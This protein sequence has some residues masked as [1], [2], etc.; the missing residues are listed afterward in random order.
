[1]LRMRNV[2][3]GHIGQSALDGVDLDI[4]AGEV[5]GLAGG[6]GS[7]KSAL[8]DILSGELEPRSGAPQVERFNG[9]RLLKQGSGWVVDGLV[10][11]G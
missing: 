4:R 6:S 9:F 2:V 3:G 7:G 1:M 10:P 11:G 8:I 5:M